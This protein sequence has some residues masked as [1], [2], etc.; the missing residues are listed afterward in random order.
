LNFYILSKRATGKEIFLT[1]FKIYLLTCWQWCLQNEQS[2]DDE[3]EVRDVTAR[4]LEPNP[5]Q[6]LYRDPN[7]AVNE[8]L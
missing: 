6:E 7:V 2:N 4:L 3:S 1:L 8:D 5:F